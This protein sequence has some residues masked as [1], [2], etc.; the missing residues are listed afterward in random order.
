MGESPRQVLT[1]K[2]A[3]YVDC[4]NNLQPL[5]ARLLHCTIYKQQQRDAEGK[6]NE[7]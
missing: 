2:F 1:V 6:L 3:D 7:K 5:R 4:E